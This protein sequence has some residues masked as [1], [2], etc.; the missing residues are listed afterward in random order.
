ML[1]IENLSKEELIERFEETTGLSFDHD[2]PLPIQCEY[3]DKLY[4]F[5]PDHECHG[6]RQASRESKMLG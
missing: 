5:I 4:Q 2:G 6:I 1:N 3:C